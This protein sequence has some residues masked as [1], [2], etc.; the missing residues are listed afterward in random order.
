MRKAEKVQ[1]QSM[2][3]EIAIPGWPRPLSHY[4]DAVTFGDLVFVSGCISIDETGALVGEGDVVRQAEV[5]HEK[6]ER[7][8]SEAGSSFTDVLKVVV[9]LTN[10]DDRV[11]ID[12]IRRQYFGAARPAST[13]VEISALAIPGALVEMEVIACMSSRDGGGTDGEA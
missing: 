7:V 9:Y 13:L 2:R 5:V 10:V 11:L 6:L 3:K 4:T 8:L 1:V 12:P